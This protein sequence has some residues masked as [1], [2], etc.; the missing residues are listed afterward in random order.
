MLASS[1]LELNFGQNLA[2]DNEH[3]GIKE[4]V[5]LKHTANCLRSAILVSLNTSKRGQSM[6]VNK[7]IGK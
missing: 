5:L 1:P 2:I 4:S 7:Y 6:W 3:N